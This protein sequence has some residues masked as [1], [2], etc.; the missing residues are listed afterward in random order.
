M[1]EKQSAT[2]FL[3][4]LQ[5]KRITEAMRE[6]RRLAV[7]QISKVSC[8]VSVDGKMARE[9][10]FDAPPTLS[11]L[12]ACAGENAV[13]LSIGRHW[14]GSRDRRPPAPGAHG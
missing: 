13:L 1:F 7:D 12:V 14:P 3:Q 9:L 6:R 4:R 5:D 11:Q 2:Q 10:I 8:Q